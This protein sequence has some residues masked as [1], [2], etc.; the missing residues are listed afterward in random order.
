MRYPIMAR[1]SGLVSKDDGSVY[2]TPTRK[3]TLCSR[4]RFSTE[5]DRILSDVLDLTG[6]NPLAPAVV[7]VGKQ[8]PVVRLG[9]VQ[10]TLGVLSCG[11]SIVIDM[12]CLPMGERQAN[13]TYHILRY[14]ECH[15]IT[16]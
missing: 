4:Q 12:V 6:N 3:G 9:D 15:C 10:P 8:H 14:P 1:H 16:R 2:L 13:R 11:T 7:A 5:R